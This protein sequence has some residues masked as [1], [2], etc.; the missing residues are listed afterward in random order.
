MT[1]NQYIFEQYL[2]WLREQGYARPGI[3]SQLPSATPRVPLPS[4]NLD[5]LRQQGAPSN[6]FQQFA[7]PPLS[8]TSPNYWDMDWVDN[9][10]TDTP[11]RLVPPEP[12]TGQDWLNRAREIG[13]G[14]AAFAGKFT[15]ADAFRQTQPDTGSRNLW[16][17]TRDMFRDAEDG[18]AL[19]EDI[20]LGRKAF[21]SFIGTFKEEIE[22][23]GAMEETLGPGY[24]HLA[25]QERIVTG[26]N[27]FYDPDAAA[28]YDKIRGTVNP[29]TGERY[30]PLE[31]AS[32]AYEQAP[33]SG[34]KRLGI[35]AMVDPLNIPGL[36]LGSIGLKALKGSAQIGGTVARQ[37][38]RKT[39]IESMEEAFNIAI[40]E[41]R[42]DDSLKLR[43]QIEL[44][45]T[46][47]LGEGV[48]G[49]NQRWVDDV[50]NPSRSIEVPSPTRGNRLWFD[51]AQPAG[52]SQRWL[53]D[54]LGTPEGTSGANRMWL[55]GM[56]RAS[57]SIP[58]TPEIPTIPTT[59][60]RRWAG[61]MAP[62]TRQPSP[63]WTQEV[64]PTYN[65]AWRRG[66]P[67]VE[68]SIPP[69]TIPTR[70]N[71]QWTG[72]PEIPFRP[73]MFDEFESAKN[74]NTRGENLAPKTPDEFA[75]TTAH[76]SEDGLTGYLIDNTGDFGNLFSNPGSP[77]GAGVRAVI[78]AVE[79]GSLTLDAY[80]GFLPRYYSKAGFEEVA[81][82]K[83]VD[84]YAPPN[85][86]YETLGRPDIVIMAYKGGD[87]ASIIDRYGSFGHMQTRRYMEDFDAAKQLA[88]D[89]ATDAGS[90]YGR[91]EPSG[92]GT[93]ITTGQRGG[94]V[95]G[96]PGTIREPRGLGAIPESDLVDPFGGRPL[97]NITPENMDRGAQQELVRS[98]GDAS[99]HDT[100]RDLLQDDAVR[101]AVDS[102][103][104]GGR[105][106][107][108]VKGR[109]DL[110]EATSRLNPFSADVYVTA[111]GKLHDTSWGWRQIV[112]HLAKTND[113]SITP[114]EAFDIGG[115]LNVVTAAQLSEG[116]LPR[117]IIAFENL[118]KTKLEP[119][120]GKQ[121]GD[122][123]GVQAS[124]M[125]RLIQARHYKTIIDD[126]ELP[127]RTKENLPVPIDANTGLPVENIRNPDGSYR[128]VLEWEPY[129]RENM[130]PDEFARVE[131][132]AEALR[133]L[134]KHERDRLVNAGIFS[135]EVADEWAT[136]RPWYHPIA[137][138]EWAEK[139]GN[140]LGTSSSPYSNVSSGVF[141]MSD[142]VAVMGAL[143]PL[144]TDTL[145]KQLVQNE[146]RLRKNTIG[147]MVVELA[148][149]RLGWLKDITKE[150]ELP[151][152]TAKA[153]PYNQKNKQGYLS[154]FVDGK[155][156]VYGGIGPRMANGSPAPLDK[157]TFDFIFGKGGL[158]SKGNYE[159]EN[160]W[161][162]IA[163]MRRGTLTTYN[164]LFM[165]R[166]GILDMFTVWLKRGVAPPGV[167]RQILKNFD[168]MTNDADNVMVDIAR[169]GGFLQSR[170]T[171]ISTQARSLQARINKA[172]FDADV[173]WNEDL[174]RSTK[175]RNK[176]DDF[177]ERG[178]VRKAAKKTGRRWSGL[179]QNIE[180]AARLEV[181]ERTIIARLGR[182][183]W[184][185]LKELS[186]EQ[187]VDELLYNYRGTP[188]RGLADH[189][190]IRE[191]GMA[192]L[193]STVNF[194][195]GGEYFRRINPYT[196]FVNAAME[197]SKL[198]LR[199][200]GVNLHPNVIPIENPV[201]GG[202]Y[203][204]Y[205]N[206]REGLRRGVTGRGDDLD[207]SRISTSGDD[208][209]DSLKNKYSRDT[210]PILE[211]FDTFLEAGSY[212][213]KGTRG[214]GA[215]AAMMRM[216]GVLAAQTSIM[217]WNL[218]HAD[219]WGYWD[220]PGWIKYSGLLILLP[221]KRGEDGEYLTDLTTGKIKP[222]F[223]VIPHRTREWSLL[224]AAPQYIMEKIATSFSD[225]PEGKTDFKRFAKALLREMTPVDNLPVFGGDDLISNVTKPFVGLREVTEELQGRDFWRDEPI[226]PYDLQYRDNADQYMPYTSP[227]ISKIANII[228]EGQ[229]YSSPMR[230]DH[231]Y[232]NIFGGT[233][234][235]AMSAADWIL[236]TIDSVHRKAKMIE[237][238]TVEE[239]VAH[240]RSLKTTSER[241]AYKAVITRQGIDVLEAFED[242][243][244][245]PRRELKSIPFLSDLAK[246]Y[247]PPY[248]GGV[249]ELGE[250]QREEYLDSLGFDYDKDQHAQLS[251]TFK[252]I[253]TKNYA[254][255]QNDDKELLKWVHKTP[256]S[257]IVGITPTQWRKRR[258]ER[259]SN[260]DFFE[261]QMVEIFG[262]K[263]I[264]NLSEDERANYYSALYEFATKAGI[265]DIRLQS[266]MLIAGYY[267]IRYPEG[268]DPDMEQV[269]KFYQAREEYIEGIRYKFGAN[270]KEF[271]EFENL[272]QSHMTAAEQ[273]YDKARTVMQGYFA[274]GED[275]DTFVPTATEYQKSL[276]R[277]Y[278]LSEGQEKA[279]F[280][281]Q[282]VIISF[283][284]IRD[285][286]R[287]N[288]VIE[289]IDA[290]GESMLD[291]VLAFW[292]G[293]GYYRNKA[294]TTQGKY[295]LNEMHGA[296]IPQR[297]QAVVR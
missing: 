199:A 230:L 257:G 32:A 55:E 53:S 159:L 178:P 5:Y 82:L 134:Y 72:I 238:T 77:K 250:I 7:P 117:A 284:A 9:I 124:D 112:D 25:R 59:A 28:A 203:W 26:I 141:S 201:P 56:Q 61:D 76:M 39:A 148:G 113:I 244:R 19:P 17:S 138:I 96:E 74:L 126:P 270:S 36:K 190:A 209:L 288:H 107:E 98:T 45:G 8:P 163:G 115:D 207:I 282:Q 30:G 294:V 167:V 131:R 213:V 211:T 189:P 78:R 92:I 106:D 20:S 228:P 119:L 111:I 58:I 185:R 84:E 90:R 31:S 268:D 146:L 195:R 180:Q 3:A 287:R 24:G 27:P 206:Y 215:N 265:Q 297:Q 249:R 135:R 120:L 125:S 29:R 236:E 157:Y 205:G 80:D 296:I 192:A 218:M 23:I 295:Y 64:G 12:V 114:Q 266:E 217:G 63:L 272:R 118:W 273:A 222:N 162:W 267:N 182:E 164:P 229:T 169:T 262:D 239:Q 14:V 285:M 196:Y 181:A 280:E 136:K 49:V 194:F 237:P 179:A 93:E 38:A 258:S 95:S 253:R 212:V 184:G 276:W 226:V 168:A 220:I 33:I 97:D 128:D 200:I 130:A 105:I 221:P 46:E 224:L 43:Q 240:Y 150:F 66:A 216:G 57:D 286:K 94:M 18:V 247:N 85:W 255:Q 108:Y 232:N 263:T 166:N 187:F 279:G 109:D 204:S 243:L 102:S 37:S 83:F 140:G 51:E 160:M 241:R 87:R 289:S 16:N 79:E 86:N 170:T 214:G 256:G 254:A 133:D 40:R 116:S 54:V 283:K 34:L 260:Y 99:G 1:S 154:V 151:N 123:I 161:G 122:K 274:I 81:R 252:R 15:G 261:K 2:P 293:D 281:Q 234:K 225:T 132:G 143:D 271:E 10:E 183:E 171:N 275:P 292:Y 13:E 145:M 144:S 231:L 219:E 155:R 202:P 129:M 11:T 149:R 177:F 68:P 278:L 52:P 158:A 277:Q 35:E 60:S 69:T 70:A 101:E 242:E 153:I 186:R 91:P 147:K 6:S 4:Y 100:A 137:Y 245:K 71:L 290:N 42:Y 191:A 73:A 89:E 246:S 44:L 139:T 88:R 156:K 251:A 227:V 67:E 65:Q 50:M 48:T 175:W 165:T 193:D 174:T 142:N 198:P 103:S 41:G 104:K 208:V 223:F 210:V 235:V 121:V 127:L 152:G 21:N 62:T 173:I 269:N 110:A 233:G 248:S 197:G 259:Y 75:N 22:A 47:G 172:G 176:I 188:G 291:S 264:Y